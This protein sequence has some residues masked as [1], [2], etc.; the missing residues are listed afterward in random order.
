MSSEPVDLDWDFHIEDSDDQIMLQVMDDDDENYC[1]GPSQDTQQMK[2]ID[3]DEIQEDVSEGS[4]EG[5]IEG[6][7]DE[8]G[9]GEQEEDDVDTRWASFTRRLYG[10]SHWLVRGEA[11]ERLENLVVS[12][13]TQL[14][15]ANADA[16]SQSG[17]KRGRGPKIMLQL[18]DRRKECSDE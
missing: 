10:R 14:T 7:V 15:E 16:Y 1:L 11:I 18:A 12:F 8:Q 3:L 9:E 4:M 17:A 2:H 5:I 13:L 6:D